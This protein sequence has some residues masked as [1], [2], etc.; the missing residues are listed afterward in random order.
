MDTAGL[1][2]Q[3][4]AYASIDEFPKG[5]PPDEQDTYV[6]ADIVIQAQG[7][8]LVMAVGGFVEEPLSDW[9]LNA[10]YVYMH[11]KC[12]WESDPYGGGTVPLPVTEHR[13][14]HINILDLPVAHYSWT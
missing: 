1:P 2:H 3:Y 4:I 11:D 7:L 14:R 10:M 6:S 8:K 9:D 12:I 13:A 5:N